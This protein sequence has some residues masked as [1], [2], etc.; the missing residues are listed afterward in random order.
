MEPTGT[1][2][3]EQMWPEL[4]DIRRRPS[5]LVVKAVRLKSK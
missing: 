3:D 1:E 2:K 4:K 5:F